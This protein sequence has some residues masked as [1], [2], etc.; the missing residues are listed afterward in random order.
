MY[1]FAI[2][3]GFKTSLSLFIFLLM[4]PHSLFAGQ[5][6]V[7]K[8]YDGD[9]IKVMKNGIEIIVRLVGGFQMP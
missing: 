7:I 2:K 5:F 9:T 8:V 3:K 1:S 6:K 4:V